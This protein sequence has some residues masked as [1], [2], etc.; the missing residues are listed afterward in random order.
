M[1]KKAKI[2]LNTYTGPEIHLLSGIPQGSALSPTL[3]TIYTADIPTA[4]PETTMMQYVDDITQII[5]YPGKLR[6]FMAIRTEN[7]INKINN[8]EH[9]WKIKPVNKNLN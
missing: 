4:G 8:Y 5:T 6:N 3:Y 9:Q 7:V 1:E 2:K